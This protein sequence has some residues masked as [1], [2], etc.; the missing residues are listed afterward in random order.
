MRLIGSAARSEQAREDPRSGLVEDEL[1]LVL[2]GLGR[3]AGERSPINIW[4]SRFEPAFEPAFEPRSDS[5]SGDQVAEPTT[6]TPSA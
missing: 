2:V 1:Q 3:H 5:E 4:Q 6:T